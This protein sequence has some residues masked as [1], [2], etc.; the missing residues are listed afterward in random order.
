MLSEAASCAISEMRF[1]GTFGDKTEELQDGNMLPSL[2][3]A[4]GAGA[5]KNE[6]Q[7]NYLTD[8]EPVECAVENLRE[9]VG[10]F[11]VPVENF[12]LVKATRDSIVFADELDKNP[13]L[14]IPDR[15]EIQEVPDA[16]AFFF[17]PNFDL[18]MHHGKDGEIK[19]DSDYLNGGANPN[20]IF[21]AGMRIADCGSLAVEMLDRNGD[22]V[23]GLIHLTRTNLRP[24]GKYIHERNGEH[25]GWVEKVIG[26]A[27]DHYGADLW[28]VQLTQLGSISSDDYVLSFSDKKKM[29]DLWP[30]WEEAG[31]IELVGRGQEDDEFRVDFSRMIN[32]QISVAVKRLGLLKYRNKNYATYAINTGDKASG[33][34]SNHWSGKRHRLNAE[35]RDIHVVGVNRDSVNKVTLAG[36]IEQLEERIESARQHYSECSGAGDFFQAEDSRSNAESMEESLARLKQR[37]EGL[38]KH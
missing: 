31:Y 36:R 28:S 21:A 9:V 10:S 32:D 29:E 24:S 23:L 22:L 2:C 8:A 13:E 1:P 11:G 30:G 19:I 20:A 38:R 35:G 15:G 18:T 26:E 3:F 16:N 17:S 37:L 27:V 33:H 12:V 7:L 6:C 14:D 25:V 34:A 5:C 4:A